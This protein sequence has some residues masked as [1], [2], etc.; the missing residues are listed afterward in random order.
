MKSNPST[1]RRALDK[2]NESSSQRS[3]NVS[4]E[5]ENSGKMKI[6]FQE[7]PKNIPSKKRE[8]IRACI[9]TG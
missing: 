3:I 7:Y 9:I 8:T 5:Q 4:K 1:L 6:A 2:A